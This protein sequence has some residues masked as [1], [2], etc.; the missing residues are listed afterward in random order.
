MSVPCQHR[1]SGVRAF[2]VYMKVVDMR[3]WRSSMC[4]CILC[5]ARI[6]RELP[7]PQHR[8][9]KKNQYLK[10]ARKFVWLVCLPLNTEPSSHHLVI[11]SKS[12]L[13]VKRTY[14]HKTFQKELHCRAI[15]N[16]ICRCVQIPTTR[17]LNAHRQNQGYCEETVIRKL[18]KHQLP[19]KGSVLW[20]KLRVRLGKIDKYEKYLNK[21]RISACVWFQGWPLCTTNNR[22]LPGRS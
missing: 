14:L 12:V 8:D 18:D 13:S 17:P 4:V 2:N 22:L 11:N 10:G 19:I 9:G 21:T 6:L 5:K 16:Q 7:F 15:A 3:V 20:L 1:T